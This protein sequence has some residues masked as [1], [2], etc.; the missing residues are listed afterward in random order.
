M[1]FMKPKTILINTLLVMLIFCFLFVLLILIN[2]YD[3]SQYKAIA[4][5]KESKAAEYNMQAAEY[6]KHVAEMQYKFAEAK[7]NAFIKTYSKEE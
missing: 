3:A 7:L 2:Y 5:S 6:N 4:A 1:M